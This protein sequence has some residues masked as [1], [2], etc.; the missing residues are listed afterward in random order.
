MHRSLLGLLA[1]ALLIGPVSVKEARAGIKVRAALRTPNVRI[2]VSNHS[3]DRRP[4]ICRTP[5]V[6]YRLHRVTISQSD[7]RIAKRLA[8]YTGVPQRELLQLRRQGYRWNEIGRWYHVP[9][10]VV[11]AAREAR[12]WQR[13][14]RQTRYQECGTRDGRRHR[15][16]YRDR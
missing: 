3:A 1:L 16:A 8:R 9:R 7:R 15:V 12:D 10:P 5:R 2:Q 11:R 4:G 6:E 13:F 14:L